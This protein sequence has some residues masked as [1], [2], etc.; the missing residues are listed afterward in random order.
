M[1]VMH[2]ITG[3]RS[4]VLCA[5]IDFISINW[6]WKKRVGGCRKIRHLE[7]NHG[8]VNRGVDPL[9]PCEIVN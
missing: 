6:G 4:A 5:L 8:S 2:R 9:F 7:M 3:G 1:N